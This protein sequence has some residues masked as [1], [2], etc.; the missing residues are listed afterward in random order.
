DMTFLD[1]RQ[2]RVSGL[3]SQPPPNLDVYLLLELRAFRMSVQAS[4]LVRVCPRVVKRL[5]AGPHFVPTMTI[6]GQVVSRLNPLS[7]FF[8][9][10]VEEQ[11]RAKHYRRVLQ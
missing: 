6:T 3:T 5:A 10:L 9:A 7:Q 2:L 11:G 4:K 1:R 8:R